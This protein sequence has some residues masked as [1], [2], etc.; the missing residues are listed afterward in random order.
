MFAYGH[1]TAADAERLRTGDLASG[2]LV[3]MAL[4]A[5]ASGDTAVRNGWRLARDLDVPIALHV[6]GGVPL[7]RIDRLAGLRPGTVYIHGTGL[8]PGEFRLMADSGGALALAPAIELTMG[9]GMPAAEAA[10]PGCGPR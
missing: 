2:G 3:T 6:R 7:V 8:A 9:H 1:G 10:A 5:E 4:N